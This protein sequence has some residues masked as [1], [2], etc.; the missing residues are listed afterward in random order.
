M[1]EPIAAVD[2]EGLEPHL[3]VLELVGR[4]GSA[5]VYRCVDERLGR[6][7]A[8]KVL[9][10]LDIRPGG[11][12]APAE[13]RTQALLSWHPFVL[14]VFDVGVG[15]SGHPYIVSEFAP[16]GALSDRVAVSGPLDP[17]GAV[18]LTG[19]L[20]E[21]LA[22]AHAA[23]VS[24]CDVKPSN[25]LFAA[26]GS[27]R[28]ADF[29][30]ARSSTVTSRTLGDLQASL[31]YASPELLDG[32]RPGPAGDLWGLALSVWTALTGLEPFGGSGQPV[33]TFVARL[34]AERP[35]FESL[36]LPPE[37]ADVL[38]RC[39]D[40]D[41]ARRPSAPD[42]V[43][44]LGGAV[45]PAAHAAG[46][47]DVV[48]VHEAS[49]R[50][51]RRL[52]AAIVADFGDP[53]ISPFELVELALVEYPRLFRTPVRAIFECAQRGG[54]LPP[55]DLVT[56]EQ[57]RRL[58]L[59]DQL[60]NLAGS[61]RFFFDGEMGEYD[62]SRLPGELREPGRLLSEAHLWV[63]ERSPGVRVG[64]AGPKAEVGRAVLGRFAE[65]GFI[66]GFFA[67]DRAF[68]LLDV[69]TVLILL[70]VARPFL[71]VLVQGR[72]DWVAELMRR[73]P[74]LR[75]AVVFEHPDFMMGVLRA[76]PGLAEEIRG[77]RWG[78]EIELGL[79][80]TSTSERAGLRIMFPAELAALGIDL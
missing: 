24:H 31:V 48:A 22:A 13:A 33:A 65:P 45:T 25:V 56:D 61:P 58:E 62:P 4:G 12:V 46:A 76:V 29:G 5:L 53:G 39:L 7:V 2:Q 10:T 27:L 69:P 70:A 63:A 36:G 77:T 57:L 60:R 19:Q 74:D 9:H 15:T 78:T 51:R 28:L 23:G 17:T 44:V 79:G 72:H 41:P 66:E 47:P 55:G 71:E 80:R 1:R 16:G 67:D 6:E 21:A 49:V 73:K 75:A 11:P 32:V 68:D 14:S 64:L 43:G 34:H 40:H 50:E 42:V 20:A 26:D 18:R 3:R 59:A 35:G 52:M 38:D 30:I 37:V 8:V 54:G